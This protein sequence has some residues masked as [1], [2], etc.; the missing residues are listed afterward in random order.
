MHATVTSLQLRGM[1]HRQKREAEAE[2]LRRARQAGLDAQQREKAAQK[3]ME[4]DAFERQL[5]VR[6]LTQHMPGGC[7][8]MARIPL[9][10][11]LA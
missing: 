7:T 1:E 5:Q 10:Y 4:Q 11:G 9:A 8:L 2:E 3:R 6:L